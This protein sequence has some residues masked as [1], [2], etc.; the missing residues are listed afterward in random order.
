MEHG[1]VFLVGLHQHEL[2]FE[3]GQPGPHQVD[4]AFECAAVLGIFL[5]LSDTTLVG[6]LE[7]LQFLPARFNLFGDIGDLSLEAG[8][9]QFYV[10]QGNQ[11]SK[12]GIH[13]FAPL[14]S[15][16]VEA[17]SLRGRLAHAPN[18]SS[19]QLG[20]S[21]Y[22]IWTIQYSPYPEACPLTQMP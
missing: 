16:H 13:L 17:G 10:L 3:L 12:I 18:L 14:E 22:G 1:R 2:I 21:W 9:L 11:A 15:S 19:M 20:S 5:Q 4:L 8:D 7:M 6:L